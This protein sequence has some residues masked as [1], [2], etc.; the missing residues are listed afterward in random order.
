MENKM[1]REETTEELF[2]AFHKSA[3]AVRQAIGWL[4]YGYAIGLLLISVTCFIGAVKISGAFPDERQRKVNACYAALDYERYYCVES[5]WQKEG[6]REI[7]DHVHK[8]C[9]F[10]EG[11]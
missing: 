9:T 8:L 6:C 4:Y 2:A 5:N 7:R 1:S 10:E 11:R 3:Q